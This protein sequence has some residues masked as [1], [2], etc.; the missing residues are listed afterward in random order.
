MNKKIIMPIALLTLLSLAVFVSATMVLTEKQNLENR[1][2]IEVQIEKG[3]NLIGGFEGQPSSTSEIQE[4]DI[5]AI[6]AFNPQNNEY[7]LVKPRSQEYDDLI[8]ADVCG[9]GSCS[10]TERDDYATWCS[11]DCWNDLSKDIINNIKIDNK[12]EFNIGFNDNQNVKL[13]D[14]EFEFYLEKGPDYLGEGVRLR[15]KLSTWSGGA[16]QETDYYKQSHMSDYDRAKLI[17]NPGEI[18]GKDNKYLFALVEE[19]QDGKYKVIWY[20][21][22][23]DNLYKMGTEYAPTTQQKI[24][25]QS[26]WL[27]SK[28]KGI[29][30]YEYN[31]LKLENIELNSGWNFMT[32]VPEMA[33]KTL[34]E[35]KGTCQIEKAY[36]FEPT[37]QDWNNLMDEQL[38]SEATGAGFVIKVMN[39]CKLQPKLNEDDIPALP[40]D[41]LPERIP[42]IRE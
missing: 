13:G 32:M 15:T 31:Y 40:G 29:L 18:K 3:W 24:L 42:P 14:F 38:Q 39:E 16:F 41:N 5:K 28:K 9:D 30:R 21:I 17:S 36:G 26:V 7:I 25:S 11:K 19:P 6:Y 20:E 37:K 33:G 23:N 1:Y 4:D 2:R 10:I 22:T 12:K 35:L 34:E 8:F 27:Y